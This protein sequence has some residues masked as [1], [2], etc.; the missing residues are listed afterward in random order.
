MK[1]PTPNPE[2]TS[3]LN[4]FWAYTL[5]ETLVRLGARYAVTAPGSRNAPLIVALSNHPEIE[6]IPVLDERSGAFYA[7]GLSKQTNTPT[8]LVASS[9]TAGAHF[10]AAIIEAHLTQ[11]PLFVIT[12]DRPPEMQ[13]CR[14]RQ[15]IQQRHLYGHYPRYYHEMALPEMNLELFHYQRQTLIHAWKEALFPRPG[16][17][18]INLPLRDPLAPVESPLESEWIGM[19]PWDVFFEH[20]RPIPL[21]EVKLRKKSLP[22]G[23]KKDKGL[24][25]VGCIEPENPRA[26]AGA[27]G[28]IAK[29]LGW[30]VLTEA[31]SPCR[32]Y[33][34][35]IAGL[36]TRYD[37][38]LRNNGFWSVLEP[39][40]ILS[41][42]PLPTSKVLLKWLEALHAET[43]ILDTFNTNADAL[44]RR[45][46][47]LCT[48]AQELD[49][50]LEN[51]H[52][53]NTFR[54]V[55]LDLEDQAETIL[56]ATLI[57]TDTLT[58]GKLAW[59]LSQHLPEGTPLFVSNSM[60]VRDMEYFAEKSNL[61]LQ[62]YFNK[63]ASG[64]D[65]ILSTAMGVMHN[66]KPGVV[67]TGD[68]AFLH[69]TNALL[70]HTYFRGHLSILV[71]NN[72]GGGIFEFLPIAQ[73]T[74]QYEKYIATPQQ[75]NFEKLVSAYGIE[76][77]LIESWS[78]LVPLVR[79]LPAQGI[80]VIEICTHRKKDMLFR[81]DLFN[82]TAQS[83]TLNIEPCQ[84]PLQTSLY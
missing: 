23:F 39:E 81:R 11:V 10:Y 38:I 71:V 56:Q 62:P 84:Q 80:R 21:P 8:I 47:P 67:L 22:G 68:L 32:Y 42:G 16:P 36:V 69:D 50:I 37:I 15:T 27:I 66:N 83:L 2:N 65:G 40:V 6:T 31:L 25:I 74:K 7:L 3:N 20:V 78:S 17:I 41:V 12:A 5:T 60:P 13:D 29:K 26:F 58:E 49:G 61:R 76:Y 82:T 18:H 52:P 73:A 14:T 64:I 24:I 59:L 9:G 19:Q 28:S 70:N 75:V 33:K 72:E 34:D 43:Y 53:A 77:H 55:W 63:G 46:L 51:N 48:S 35:E 57:N 4:S 1:V 45:A 54:N 44:H 30:A 79:S